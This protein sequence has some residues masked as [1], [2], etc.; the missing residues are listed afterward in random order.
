MSGLDWRGL[1]R[2]GLQ[3]M[4]LSPDVFWALTP[5]ELQM[6]LG[7]GGAVAPLL[8]TGLERLMAAWPDE[9]RGDDGVSRRD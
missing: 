5:A 9:E 3:E 6:M 8:H 4:R 7:G 1:M 2:V